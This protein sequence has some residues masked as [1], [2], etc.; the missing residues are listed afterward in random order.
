MLALVPVAGASAARDG[1]PKGPIM[2]T[3]Q[4]LEVRGP[5]G[6]ETSSN[7]KLSKTSTFVKNKG[8]ISLQIFNANLAFKMAPLA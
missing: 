6:P 8:F 3:P 7:K 2:Y 1:G 5:L 4:G